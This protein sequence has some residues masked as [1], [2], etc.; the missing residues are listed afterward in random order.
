[1]PREALT[2][3]EMAGTYAVTKIKDDE[4]GPFL[5]NSGFVLQV[6]IQDEGTE[7][8]GVISKSDHRKASRIEFDV[9][10]SAQD[11]KVQPNWVLPYIFLRKEEIQFIEFELT[12]TAPGR[13]VISVEFLYQCHWLAAI[14]LEID[15]V[16]AQDLDEVA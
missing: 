13:K 2:R 9:V 10:V 14:K 3:A 7:R 15:V 4:S 1:M 8:L 5:T 16:E 11:I 6:G 12:P